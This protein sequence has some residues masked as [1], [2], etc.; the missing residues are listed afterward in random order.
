MSMMGYLLA[1][2]TAAIAKIC[3]LFER[4]QLLGVTFV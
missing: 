2:L 3:L 4:L 1:M